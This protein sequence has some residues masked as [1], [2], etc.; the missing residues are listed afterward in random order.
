M[1][2]SAKFHKR[3]DRKKT[4]STPTLSKTGASTQVEQHTAVVSSKKKA[5]LKGKAEKRKGGEGH[6]LGGADYV[7]LMMGGRRK[8][9]EEAAKLTKESE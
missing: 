8:V 7:S 5:G 6:V 2:R 3:V 1:G 9:K 4:Q